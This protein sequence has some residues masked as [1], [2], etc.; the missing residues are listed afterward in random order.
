[1][2]RFVSVLGVAGLVLVTVIGSASAYFA[3]GWPETCLEM[4]DM[5]EASPRGSGAVGIYQ[6]AFGARA[7]TL[8]Q[9]DHRNDVRGTFGWAFGYETVKM[10]REPDMYGIYSYLSPD[11]NI[12]F[13]ATHD[14]NILFGHRQCPAFEDSGGF[15][16][17]NG[18]IVV[19]FDEVRCYKYLDFFIDG[20]SIPVDE[21]A[22]AED[23]RLLEF[24]A[25]SYPFPALAPMRYI[26]N[27]VD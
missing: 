4:N 20:I 3:G 6:R 22:H 8:C 26:I 17:V 2:R 23:V 21:L 27:W 11:V 25:D 9:A 14:W 1:M 15:M 13:S 24:Y 10:S 19:E 16:V 12:A 18:S 5:V 7:E